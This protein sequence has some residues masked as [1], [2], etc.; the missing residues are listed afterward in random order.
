MNVD[1]YGEVVNGE[2][3]YKKIADFLKKDGSFLIGWTDEKFTHYD[4][5]FSYNC[6]GMGVF[7]R[8]IKISDLFVSI[9]SVGSFGFKVDTEKSIGYVGE[10]LFYGKTDISVEKI[11][12]LINGIIK[13]L[14]RE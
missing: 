4:I 12:Q 1:K 7:Q 2:K 5:L 13:N 11:T 9:I 3:T 10:K 6:D 8:G 14:N